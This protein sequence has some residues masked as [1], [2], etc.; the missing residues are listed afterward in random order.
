MALASLPLRWLRL[1]R[2]VLLQCIYFKLYPRF[3]L[4]DV[5]SVDTLFYY[6]VVVLIELSM[7]GFEPSR[8]G[9]TISWL[10]IARKPFEISNF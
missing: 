1:R 9:S 4:F 6:Y 5:K 10:P 3:Q 2:R 8:A 7:R